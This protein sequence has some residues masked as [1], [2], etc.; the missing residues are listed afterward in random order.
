MSRTKTET[1]VQNMLAFESLS[2]NIQRKMFA[3]YISEYS[4]KNADCLV[5]AHCLNNNITMLQMS[6]TVPTICMYLLFTLYPLGVHLIRFL[7][8]RS[9]LAVVWQLGG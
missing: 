7:A 4:I 8:F 5:K 9:E 2:T 6:I 3:M 1:I